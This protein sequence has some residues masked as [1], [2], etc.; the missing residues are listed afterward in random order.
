MA[1]TEIATGIGI[2]LTVVLP[3]IAAPAAAADRRGRKRHLVGAY[4][5][6]GDLVDPERL[7]R[8]SDF[9]HDKLGVRTHRAAAFGVLGD[10][11][12]ATTSITL[13]GALA[14]RH[15]RCA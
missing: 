9:L 4:A 5:T 6:V 1:L 13:I 11:L 10:A 12:G 2:P 7:P 15:C 3:D 14:F 8:C